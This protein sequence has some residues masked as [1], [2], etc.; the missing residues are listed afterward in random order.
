[1]KHMG[2]FKWM[3]AVAAL[4]CGLVWAGP[5]VAAPY[6]AW[7][8][9]YTGSEAHTL[10]LWN[11]NEGA[12]TADSSENGNTL[13]IVSPA[14]AQAG[15][16]FGWGLNVP[17]S[18][19]HDSNAQAAGSTGLFPTGADPSLSIEMWVKFKESNPLP[20]SGNLLMYLVDKYYG[21][22]TDKGGYQI[23]YQSDS[24]N[25]RYLKFIV[26]SGSSTFT[27]TA[28]NPDFQAN[29]WYHLAAV[30]DA[31]TDTSTLYQ[32]G[33]SIGSRAATTPFSIANDSARLVRIGNRLGSS[34]G[35]FDGVIDGVRISDVAYQ[36][37]VPE[38]ALGMML[39]V[40]GG[41]MLM[42]RRRVSEPSA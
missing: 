18:T 22:A 36:F 11:F 42:R 19:D 14:A 26:G 34:Y 23:F 40:L 39:L 4:G 6:T 32:N 25:N 15:G 17:R 10:A 27:L 28:T 8:N 16:K 31:A 12:T 21:A 1:M 20:D 30:Y 13:A 7:Q 2:H 29:T 9:E 41:G 3:A 33:I 24:N 37:A 5:A 38:P 35:S